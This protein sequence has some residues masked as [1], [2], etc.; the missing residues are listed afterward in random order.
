MQTS[1]HRCQKTDIDRFDE[2]LEI[3]INVHDPIEKRKLRKQ[4]KP[5]MVQESFVEN[6]I[7]CVEDM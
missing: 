7:A 2:L 3:T 5:Q 1:K 6:N 4:R